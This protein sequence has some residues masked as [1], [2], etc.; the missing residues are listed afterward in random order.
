MNQQRVVH[1][2]LDGVGD[3]S[4]SGR[5]NTSGDFPTACSAGPGPAS[6][7]PAPASVR[8]APDARGLRRRQR[9][10]R[11]P[12]AAE[13]RQRFVL[14]DFPPGS[15]G[16]FNGRLVRRF[17]LNYGRSAY[18]G[19]RGQYHQQAQITEAVA[20]IELPQCCGA[21]HR[22]ALSLARSKQAA[23]G[24]RTTLRYEILEGRCTLLVN[25]SDR[26]HDGLRIIR[27]YC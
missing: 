7:A 16:V 26:R 8:F 17:S 20:C 4:R 5:A 3:P 18:S 10:A 15:L 2:E 21:A 13:R 12:A 27:E 24:E 19:C 11:Q 1:D 23:F 14:F 9:I 6:A 22:L 25:R